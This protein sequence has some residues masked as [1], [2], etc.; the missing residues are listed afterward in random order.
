MGQR[1]RGGGVGNEV[2]EFISTDCVI[3]EGVVNG[4]IV[5]TIIMVVDVVVNG[6]V[7]SPFDN[8][9]VC[10]DKGLA[11][12]FRERFNAR[13]SGV[14]DG[15]KGPLVSENLGTSGKGHEV[16]VPLG[17][18]SAGQCDGAERS[19]ARGVGQQVVLEYLNIGAKFKGEG[20]VVG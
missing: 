14:G 4:L 15:N 8:E 20:I 13:N 18:A 9:A 19:G 1:G 6:H 12:L 10:L 17:V 7:V 16:I 11:L 3:V 5:A 2:S